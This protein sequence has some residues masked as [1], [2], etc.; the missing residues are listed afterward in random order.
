[1]ELIVASVLG[2]L[3]SLWLC[4]V[5]IRPKEYVSTPFQH[6]D[7]LRKDESRTPRNVWKRDDV[8]LHC[9]GVLPDW[10]GHH[11]CERLSGISKVCSGSHHLQHDFLRLKWCRGWDKQCR[12]METIKA[13][14][15]ICFG[16]TVILL[17]LSLI[18]ML[19]RR[20]GL[21]GKAHGRDEPTTYPQTRQTTTTTTTAV[22]V[23][24]VSGT[25]TTE[26]ATPVRVTGTV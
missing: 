2:I 12:I 21:G 7:Y 23:S 6:H 5:S 26:T 9:Y 25:T 20:S 17:L 14:S 8:S 3:F 10:C 11:H 1:M 22:P 19:T 13:F 16:F 15:W 18:N 24:A 4:V